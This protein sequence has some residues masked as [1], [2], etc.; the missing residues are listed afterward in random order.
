MSALRSAAG[1]SI[2]DDAGAASAAG[3]RTLSVSPNHASGGIIES[4]RV[5]CGNDILI[6]PRVLDVAAADA[7]TASLRDLVD[8]AR[9]ESARLRQAIDDA[10]ARESQITRASRQLHE[11]LSLGARMLKAFQA[12]IDALETAAAESSER[13]RRAASIERS[14]LDAA[15]SLDAA[16]REATEQVDRCRAAVSENARAIEG[17]LL[18]CREA[19]AACERTVGVLRG[20]TSQAEQA[21]SH[22][23][24]DIADTMRRG[25]GLRHELGPLVE[26]L[27]AVASGARGT[28]DR[29][30]SAL[31]ERARLESLLD[32]LDTWRDLLI[33]NPAPR[34]EARLA[35]SAARIRAG[36]QSEML[37][38]AAAVRDLGEPFAAPDAADPPLIEVTGDHER[39]AM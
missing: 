21:R 5:T 15:Q 20:L 10:A 33:E 12:Q 35:E 29:L 31:A 28:V 11:R 9:A 32:R 8:S 14:A 4:K 27:E 17:V 38:L 16:R 2:G 13:E 24:D 22:L 34:I 30:D 39:A 19:N 25:D 7:F 23:A 26:S 6:S 1:D 36:L 18:A 3:H 37:R